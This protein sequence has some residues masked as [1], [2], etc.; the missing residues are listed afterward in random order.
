MTANGIVTSFAA[1]FEALERGFAEAP[2][3]TRAPT[4][5]APQRREVPGGRNFPRPDLGRA[6]PGF[7]E[8]FPNLVR[9]SVQ[10]A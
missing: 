1:R 6:T 10:N 9:G 5:E 2:T 8:L 3:S 7:G 4:A